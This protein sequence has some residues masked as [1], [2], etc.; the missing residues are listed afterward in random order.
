VRRP[1]VLVVVAVVLAVIGVSFATALDRP[2]VAAQ[3]ATPAF[4]VNA[5]LRPR[6]ATLGERVQLVVTVRHSQDLLVS[7]DQPV[8]V[9]NIDL[10]EAR[11]EEL[12][13]DDPS[14]GTPGMATTTFEFT[15]AAYSLGD[16]HPGDIRVS[17]L[18]SDGTTGG[19]VVRPP[20]LRIVPVR[21]SGDEELRP[22]K[23]Q[24]SAGTPP[25]WWQRSEVPLGLGGVALAAAAAL[26]WQ[27]RRRPIAQ[28]AVPI[29]DV[30]SPEDR[31]RA[32]LDALRG[33][34]LVDRA[35]Y[36]HFYGELSIATRAYLA[37]RHGF[38][39]TA[40]TTGELRERFAGAGVG[41]WQARLVAG[42]L[43][44]C[45]AAVYARAQPDPASADHDL[46][47]AYEIVE[48]SRPRRGELRQA[49]SA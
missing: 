41:R 44:R 40:L 28:P 30:R 8:R 22:L 47:V 32:R 37:E 14:T 16:L 12:V 46:T 38:N 13:F 25:A 35:A 15:I 11:P 49:V 10:L 3:E 17:W 20:I 7:S 9:E 1:A 36:R 23:P 6:A 29:E 5:S 18:A 31:A 2:H 43:E 19:D 48:L 27:R 42:L 26:A 24:A 21:A 34:A 45:D 39:A 33:V 4:E